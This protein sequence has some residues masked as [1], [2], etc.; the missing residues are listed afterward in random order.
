M[1]T[2]AELLA[3]VDDAA[4]KGKK[5]D[6]A[7]S[8]PAPAAAVQKAEE[9]LGLK[10]PPTYKEFVLICDGARFGGIAEIYGVGELPRHRDEVR[11]RYG[12]LASADYL[13]IGRRGDVPLCF[14]LSRKDEHGEHPIVVAATHGAILNDAAPTFARLV[15]E[16]VK[17][18]AG[19]STAPPGG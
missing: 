12:A 11:K 1:A 16:L 5:I 13:P 2:V 9:K 4:R 8:K 19:G 15:F 7:R 10:L 14:D 6:L 3:K 18:L 17:Q